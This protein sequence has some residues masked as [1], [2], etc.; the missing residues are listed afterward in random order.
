MKEPAIKHPTSDARW[1]RLRQQQEIRLP[2]ASRTVAAARERVK[3]TRRMIAQSRELLKQ[4]RVAL[5]TSRDVRN[6]L[7]RVEQ[8]LMTD[9]ADLG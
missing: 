3:N 1:L 2:R 6:A 7:K 9:F 5:D 4:A 8:R